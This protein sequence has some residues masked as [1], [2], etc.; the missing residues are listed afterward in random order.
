VFEDKHEKEK[1]RKKRLA[2][3]L[4]Y[5]YSGRQNAKI[6]V[7]AP[8]KKERPREEPEKKDEEP[9]NPHS[10]RL[11][12]VRNRITNKRERSEERWNRFAGTSDGGGRGR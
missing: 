3:F 10:P 7:A 4:F 6:D 5:L 2:D 1:K 12:M 8:S 9:E 11:A